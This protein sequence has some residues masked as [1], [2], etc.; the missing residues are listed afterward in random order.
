MVVAAAAIALG[1]TGLGLQMKGA[2]EEGKA[3]EA[4]AKSEAAWQEYNAKLAER[5]AT[6]A[7]TAAAEEEKKHR[8]AAAR[9]K[10]RARTQAGKAG[11]EPIGSFEKVHEETVVELEADALNI[12]RSGFVGAQRLIGEAQLSRLKGRS[13]LFR[14]RAARRAGRLKAIGTGLS[15]GA[16]LI[17]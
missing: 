7:Q 6:E 5:E 16:G 1:A 13:A 8:K 17:P 12:R 4:K 2:H 3:L 14:G 15:G 10:A 11:I 9:L